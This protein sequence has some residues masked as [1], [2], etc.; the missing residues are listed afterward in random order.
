MKFKTVV[1]CLK[2]L[3]CLIVQR[4]FVKLH[5][6]DEREDVEIAAPKERYISSEER[7]QIIEE[8]RLVCINV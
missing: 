7:K 4:I 1:L 5:N 6:K 2:L 8:L 3:A